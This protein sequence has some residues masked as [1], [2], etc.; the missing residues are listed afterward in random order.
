M[1]RDSKY[2]VDHQVGEGPYRID[3]GVR[4]PQRQEHHMLAVECDGASYHSSLSARER[5]R[6]RQEVLEGLGWKFHRIWSTDWFY[7]REAEI[8]K[9]K[10]ALEEAQTRDVTAAIQGANAG[11]RSAGK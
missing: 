3:L 1:I 2:Q 9:L 5:D 11:G 6:L 8:K 10:Q 4:N 7:R